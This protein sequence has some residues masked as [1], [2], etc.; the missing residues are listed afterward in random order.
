MKRGVSVIIICFAVFAN[1]LWGSGAAGYHME[2]GIQGGGGYYAGDATKHI[3]RDVKETY[4]GHFRYKFDRRWSLQAKGLYH[5]IGG[6]FDEE[7]VTKT[8]T[9]VVRRKWQNS[10]ANVDVMC[11]FNF[12]RLGLSEYDRRIKRYS[13]YVFVGFGLSLYNKGFSTVGCYIPV[14][15]GFK[16]NFGQRFGIN[17]AWQHNIYL[18]DNLENIPRYGNTFKMNGSNIMNNDITSQFTLAF[19]IELI[20]KNRICRYCEP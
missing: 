12:F 5:H 7:V 18:K 14:G 19:I 10:M 16:Y 13:P 1:L 15:I 20:R 11:E 17:I 4:G 9:T 8:E 3:F 2:I 6:S